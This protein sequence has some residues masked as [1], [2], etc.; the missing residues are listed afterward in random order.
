[1]GY[2]NFVWNYF[3]PRQQ[4]KRRLSQWSIIYFSVQKTRWSHILSVEYQMNT[5]FHPSNIRW[6]HIYINQGVHAPNE[7]TFPSAKYQPDKLT[8]SSA[9][10]QMNTQL[11]QSDN[12]W[13][14]I[15]ITQ[16]PDEHMVSSITWTS[17]HKSNFTHMFIN[18]ISAVSELTFSFVKY[19]M[20]THLYQSN[21]RETYLHQSNTRWTHIFINQITDE[22]TFS[23]VKYQMNSH[24]HQW[25]TKWTHISSSHIQAT[26]SQDDIWACNKMGLV[27]WLQMTLC[28]H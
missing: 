28:L 20:N 15:F 24:C 8:F 6:T 1:M 19:Q 5:H 27:C 16:I 22:Y 26:S 10:Y 21:I 18:Q 7:H 12:K 23:S 3:H 4:N 13:T 2:L 17:F 11:H 25:Y 9:K 14:H